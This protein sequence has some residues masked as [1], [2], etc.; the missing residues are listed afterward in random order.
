MGR[1]MGLRHIEVN[2]NGL[3]LGAR[4]G[5]AR[6]LAD[7]GVSAIYLQFDGF[8]DNIYLT[9]RKRSLIKLKLK[10]IENCRKNNLAVVLVPTIVK[11]VNDDQLGEIIHFAMRESIVKGVNI[12][13]ATFL[14]RF[15]S[16]LQNT[17]ERMTIPDVIKAIEAQTGGE[18]LSSDF[19]P[20][21][22]L[23]HSCSAVTIALAGEEGLVPLPRLV[24]VMDVVGRVENLHCAVTKA[25]PLIWDVSNERDSFERLRRY[26]SRIGAEIEDAD[27]KKILSISMMAFQDCWTLDCDR[28]QSCRVHVV[29]PNGR[30]IPFCAYYLTSSDGR[31]LYG[32]SQEVLESSG[33]D[34][35]L[36]VRKAVR[37]RYSRLAVSSQNDCCGG[38]SGCC[39]NSDLISLDDTVPAEASS[40]KAGCGSPLQLVSP[41]QGDVVLDLGSGGGIDIFK[42]SRLVGRDGSAIGVDA[43]PEMVW[44]ARETKSKYGTRYENAEFRLGEIEHLPVASESVDYVIS[45]CVINLSPDK[46]AVLGEAFRVLKE[47]GTFAVADVTLQKEIPAEARKDMDSWSACVSGAITDSEYERLLRGA[48]FQDVRIEH[49]SD[50]NIGKFQ[51]AYFS[52]HIRAK[53]PIGSLGPSRRL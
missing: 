31:R 23:H 20:I 4:P 43:T 6:E 15:P 34:G 37:D 32:P 22:S 9:M 11:G 24:D 26:L 27:S 42:A 52:S 38:G 30:V 13:P 7:A 35:E 45:N 17:T 16:D 49:V 39:D 48:G 21:P 41:R 28:M 25:I 53:K 5:L 29:R 2:T 36:P 51:Y 19:F 10:A 33:M 18:I 12:Q 47:G 3:L 44:R 50:S 1:E 46:L 14:G 40:V 8:N